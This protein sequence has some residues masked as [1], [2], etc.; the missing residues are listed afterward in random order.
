MVR[1]SD[2]SPHPSLNKGEAM[3][4]LGFQKKW[5]KLDK[6]TFTTFRYPRRD[7]DWE[8]GE[9]VKVVVKPRS[10]DREYLG[11]AEIISIELDHMEDISDDTA[12]QDGFSDAKDMV[13]WLRKTFSSN[14][15]WVFCYPMNKLTLRWE[16]RKK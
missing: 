3:R 5:A 9:L 12:R 13:A 2:T 16:G 6:P 10:K 1:G 14:D 15:R 11:Y 7:R 8:V 4:I